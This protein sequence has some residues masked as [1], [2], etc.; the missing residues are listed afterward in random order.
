MKH[1]VFAITHYSAKDKEHMDRLER[2]YDVYWRT[3]VEHGAHIFLHD[4]SKKSANRVAA[5][6]LNE[7]P[8]HID[9][10]YDLIEKP[11]LWEETAFAKALDTDNDRIMAELEGKRDSGRKHRKDLESRMAST[12]DSA[13]ISAEIAHAVEELDVLEE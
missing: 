7:I 3:M 8:A 12:E 13:E 9:A 2:T 4:G 1:V 6:L 5:L 11:D 10:V